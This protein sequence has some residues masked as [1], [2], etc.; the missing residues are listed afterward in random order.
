MIETIKLGEVFIL[1]HGLELLTG[2]VSK[3]TKTRFVVT[4]IDGTEKGPFKA[5]FKMYHLDGEMQSAECFQTVNGT[6][7]VVAFRHSDAMLEKL[8]ADIAVQ[9]KKT[10]EQIAEREAKQQSR[11]A[12]LAAEMAAAV[13]AVGEGGLASILK[14]R[15]DLP[16]GSRLYTCEIPIKPIENP[17]KRFQM[18][19]IRC[20]NLVTS[21]FNQETNTTEGR[22][23]VKMAY[24]YVTDDSSSFSSVSTTE[25][26]SEND[27]IWSA[28]ASE[29][30]SW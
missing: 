20:K 4:G 17:R 23:I 15:L 1:K 12:R 7:N 6:E 9:A 13:E 2:N 26:A 5:D 14:N 3:V 19:I 25:H 8:K 21:R 16:D 10:S 28:I 29:Y 27:A 18:L 11:L 30:H 22:Q 24:T